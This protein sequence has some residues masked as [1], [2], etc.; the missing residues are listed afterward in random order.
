MPKPDTKD[1]V[2]YRFEEEKD[3][4]TNASDVPILHANAHMPSS[5][6]PSESLTRKALKLLSSHS[7][8]TENPAKTPSESSVVQTQFL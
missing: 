2:G 1:Y 3:N 5:N 8:C 4:G 7:F 6:C